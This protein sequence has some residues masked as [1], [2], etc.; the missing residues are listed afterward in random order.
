MKVAHIICRHFVNIGKRRTTYNFSTNR[1]AANILVYNFVI[2]YMYYCLIFHTV[3][4]N[5]PCY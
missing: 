1:E 2:L 3:M 4:G 5:S